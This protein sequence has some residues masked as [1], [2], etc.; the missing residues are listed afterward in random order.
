VANGVLLFVFV[1]L[2]DFGALVVLVVLV[3]GVLALA[4]VSLPIVV[5][6]PVVPS[7]IGAL[8]TISACSLSHAAH[9]PAVHFRLLNTFSLLMQY[10][11]NQ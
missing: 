1:F 10:I 11:R 9:L 3:V 7:P 6:A 5:P 4:V 8:S 2:V